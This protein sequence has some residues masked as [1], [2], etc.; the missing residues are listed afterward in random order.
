MIRIKFRLAYNIVINISL[1]FDDD[2]NRFGN[3]AALLCGLVLNNITNID[4]R[5]VQRVE[6]V[7]AYIFWICT[8]LCLGSS[9]NIMVT[10]V[11]AVI[12]GGGLALR[13]QLGSM[14]RAVDG[15]KIEQNVMLNQYNLAIYSYGL[16]NIAVFYVIMGQLPATLGTVIL[17]I[18]MPTWYYYSVRIYNRFKFDAIST[19]F[20][21]EKST[22][23]QSATMQSFVRS[24]YI[25][26][27]SVLKKNSL[28]RHYFVLIKTDLF[29]FDKKEDFAVEGLKACRDPPIPVQAFTL[30]ANHSGD[31]YRLVLF[32]RRNG[33]SLPLE[34]LC[35]TE[36][37]Y[38]SWKS[39]LE[40]VCS[41]TG[42]DSG[43]FQEDVLFIS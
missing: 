32:P 41:S 23:T 40:A 5:E 18:F 25:Q 4:P 37:E 12:Y 27:G 26:T 13:G 36:E 31:Q 42:A 38:I 35:D 10:S 15:M 21:T 30:K 39:S 7:E 9:L 24:K 6:I 1:Q 11:C 17:A 8:A 3:R 29:R 16:S 43:A 2:V 34:I 28:K 19:T 20:R 14:S 33:D 22:T